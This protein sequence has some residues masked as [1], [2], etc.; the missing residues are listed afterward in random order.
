MQ[1]FHSKVYRRIR[2]SRRE[3]RE[4]GKIEIP[5]GSPWKTKSQLQTNSIGSVRSR[6]GKRRRWSRMR[7]KGVEEFE[8]R[9][10]KYEEER[11]RELE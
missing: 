8:L 10:R 7:R 2:R 11:E 5:L 4:V 6:E 1:S 9:V 3:S